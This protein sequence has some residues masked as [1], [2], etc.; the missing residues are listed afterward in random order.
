VIVDT[1]KIEARRAAL[2]AIAEQGAIDFEPLIVAV[3][4]V[5]LRYNFDE[6]AVVA[7]AWLSGLRKMCRTVEEAVETFVSI[8]ALHRWTMQIGDPEEP[9]LDHANP[10]I[11]DHIREM[12]D[13]GTYVARTVGV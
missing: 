9:D 5:V 1:K 12:I 11:R 8:L 10:Q 4:H 7:A 3:D 2:Q 13:L 6:H